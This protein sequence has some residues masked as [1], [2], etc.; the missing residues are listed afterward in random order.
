MTLTISR[1]QLEAAALVVIVDEHGAYR[2]SSVGDHG[3]AAVAAMLRGIGNNAIR[4][5]IEQTT[6]PSLRA[7]L[8]ASWEDGSRRDLDA[9]VAGVIRDLRRSSGISFADL[10]AAFGVSRQAAWE[11]FTRL[12]SRDL[13]GVSHG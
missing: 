12:L 8:L 9:L 11:R 5:A 3:P 2:W 7:R 4:Q 10:G 6:E 1:D 13:E